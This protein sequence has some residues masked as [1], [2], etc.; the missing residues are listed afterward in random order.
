MLPSMH[1]SNWISGCAIFA[2]GLLTRSTV[3]GVAGGLAGGVG[4]HAGTAVSRV[5]VELTIACLSL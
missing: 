4:I 2:N 1:L 5:A 3:A